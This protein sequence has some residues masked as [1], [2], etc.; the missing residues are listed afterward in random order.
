LHIKIHNEPKL[1]ITKC[2]C[3]TIALEIFKTIPFKNY[4]MLRLVFPSGLVTKVSDDSLE[5][6]CVYLP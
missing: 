3:K 2:V 5:G 6:C 1:L 4:G